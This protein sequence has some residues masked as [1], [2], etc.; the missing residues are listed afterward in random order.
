MAN[1]YS[2]ECGHILYLELPAELQVESYTITPTTYSNPVGQFNPTSFKLYGCVTLDSTLDV[3]NMEA[4]TWVLIDEQTNTG[5]YDKNTTFTLTLPSVT[6]AFK[7]FKIRMFR[8]GVTSNN[9]ITL[10]DLSLYGYEPA[11]DVIP[12]LVVPSAFYSTFEKAA[13]VSGVSAFSSVANIDAVYPAIAFTSDVDLTN[14]EQVSAFFTEHVEP[15]ATGVNRYEVK[16]LEDTVMTHAYSNIDDNTI[17]VPIELTG[18]YQIITAAQDSSGNIGV[19]VFEGGAQAI[20]YTDLTVLPDSTAASRFAITHPNDNYGLVYDRTSSTTNWDGVETN[21][22]VDTSVLGAQYEFEWGQ[23]DEW[24]YQLSSMLNRLVLRAVGSG[25]YYY[26]AYGM[27]WYGKTLRYGYSHTTSS[28][29]GRVSNININSNNQY[30]HYYRL[31]VV[32]PTTGSG[33]GIN[34]IF[35]EVFNDA[36]RTDKLFDAHMT[37]TTYKSYA[38]NGSWS[39]Y[40]DAADQNTELSIYVGFESGTSTSYARAATF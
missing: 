31:T 19:G 26:A 10:G 13:L 36:D 17:T 12:H 38:V 24:D 25:D 8:D 14:T 20:E 35:M 16:T 6:S 1:H 33:A 27:G 22:I 5:S 15:I 29:S 34:D 23:P 39:N 37:E 7:S 30:Y 32:P 3:T 21:A 2:R 9:H 11:S 40:V 18:N 28:F 4:L